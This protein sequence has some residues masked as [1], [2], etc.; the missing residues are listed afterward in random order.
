MNHDDVITVH[1]TYSAGGVI[2]ALIGSLLVMGVVVG[3]I[4][5]VYC[6]RRK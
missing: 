1:D 6:W 2:G 5:A 4:I 3:V